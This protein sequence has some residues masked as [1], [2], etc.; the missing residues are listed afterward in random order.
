M[1]SRTFPRHAPRRSAAVRGWWA[2][3]VA[4]EAEESAY[5]PGDWTKGARLARRGA[6]G[7][8]RVEAGQVVAA[9]SE[10]DDVQTVQVEVEV[11]S[12]DEAQTVA[13]V[14]AGAAGWVGT[15][16]SSRVPDQLDEGLEESGVELVPHG[17]LRS[18]CT[19]DAWVDPCTHALAV[20]LQVA[21][22]VEDEPLTL[23]HLRGLDR[24]GLTERVAATAR[25]GGPEP[26]GGGEPDEDLAIALEAAEWAAVALEQE[27]D[28]DV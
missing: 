11:F 17:G 19:C 3:S 9:V 15:L 25:P 24:S 13:E 23:L 26:S 4:S 27:D 28:A 2:R 21:W 7:E 12:A 18:S 8:I 22:W 14:V 16:L 20:L 10:G 6:V 5:D 1:T